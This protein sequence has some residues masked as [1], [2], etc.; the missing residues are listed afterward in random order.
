MAAALMTQWLFNF[1][2]AK[3]R[4]IHTKPT[5]NQQIPNIPHQLTP[6]MLDRITYGTFLVFGSACIIMVVYAV[7][8]VPE[9]KGVPLESIYMLFEGNIIAGATRD[10]VPRLS[11]AKHLA[12]SSNEGRYRDEEDDEEEGAG[13]GKN[14]SMSSHVERVDP[15]RPVA[16]GMNTAGA[17]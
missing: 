17:S 1:V 9:T 14:G 15:A 11:R 6:I 12:N 2:I 8:C 13:M 7:L 10:V 4:N 3:V 5:S 16:Y